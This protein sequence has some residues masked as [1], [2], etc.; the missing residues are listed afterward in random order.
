MNWSASVLS[1]LSADSQPSLMISFDDAK[2]MFN[3][4]EGTVRSHT[5]CES[6][7]RKMKALFLT[8][9]SLERAGGIAGEFGISFGPGTLFKSIQSV[10]ISTRDRLID[11]YRRCKLDKR[12]QSY[13]VNR[14]DSSSCGS[15]SLHI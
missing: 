5:H 12:T 3:A 13:W 10:L 9:L 11:D 4:G 15:A 1:A 2:Y 8:Q 14:V 7:R 6:N